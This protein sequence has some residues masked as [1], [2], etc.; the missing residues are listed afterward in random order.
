MSEVKEGRPAGL[1]PGLLGVREW[2]LLELPCEKQNV[3]ALV[4][5]SGSLARLCSLRPDPGH[6]ELN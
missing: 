1:E 3:Y 2:W 4:R 5:A 6:P